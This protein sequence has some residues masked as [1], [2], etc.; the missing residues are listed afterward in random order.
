MGH[1]DWKAFLQDVR[2]VDVDY[3]QDSMDIR[4]KEQEAIEQHI[5]IHKATS[6]SPTAPL[7][8]QLSSV[9]ISGQPAVP[10]MAANVDPFTN[11]GGSQGNLRFTMNA[12]VPR[13]ARPPF[14]GPNPRPPPTPEQK[15]ELHAILNRLPHHPN[16]IPGHQAHQAQQADWVDRKSTRLNSSHSS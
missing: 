4:N 8:Q 1:A 16:S 12:A 7:Q 2:N 11:A 5:R 6:K 13:Q 9:T 3:I 14:A 15:A 10:N